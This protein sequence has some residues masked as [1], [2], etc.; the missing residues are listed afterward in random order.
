MS[1]VSS[2][3]ATCISWLYGRRGKTELPKG[4][5][6]TV[7]LDIGTGVTKE[8]VEYEFITETVVKITDENG[9]VSIYPLDRIKYLSIGKE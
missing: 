7:G 2:I 9:N 6:K 4:H 5:A 3:D 1:Y 8:N